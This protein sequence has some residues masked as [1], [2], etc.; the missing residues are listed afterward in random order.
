MCSINDRVYCYDLRRQIE[1]EWLCTCEAIADN[2]SQRASYVSAVC[3]EACS[4]APPL[5]CYGCDTDPSWLV[6]QAGHARYEAADASSMW[7]QRMSRWP[8]VPGFSPTE[9]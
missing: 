5:D 7:N 3:R 6:D 1:F 2:F 9:Y 4:D 8:V